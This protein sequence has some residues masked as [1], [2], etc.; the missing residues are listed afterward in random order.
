MNKQPKKIHML[1][2]AI[3]NKDYAAAKPLALEL[4]PTI[5]YSKKFDE[6]PSYWVIASL[7]GESHEKIYPDEFEFSKAVLDLAWTLPVNEFIESIRRRSSC[8]CERYVKHLSE[9]ENITLRRRAI[10][11]FDGKHKV[12]NLGEMITYLLNVTEH[13]T[14]AWEKANQLEELCKSEALLFKSH[15]LRHGLGVKKNMFDSFLAEIQSVK[16]YKEENATGGT[17]YSYYGEY[18]GVVDEAEFLFVE[19][20]SDS[21]FEMSRNGFIWYLT[22]SQEAAP[23]A[24]AIR[25]L[26][27]IGALDESKQRLY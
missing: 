6:T 11:Y 16:A 25:E 13:Y 14:L 5:Q 19:N 9:E 12:F 4:L 15:M 2:E 17:S 24:V 7:N 21:S 22:Q 3:K 27:A 18:Y 23:L 10:N 20:S 1:V 8:F 26:K